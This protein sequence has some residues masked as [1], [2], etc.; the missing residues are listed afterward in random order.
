M[1]NIVLIIMLIFFVGAILSVSL[2]IY[3]SY[4]TDKEKTKLYTYL[5]IFMVYFIYDMIKNK[6]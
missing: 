4:K 3:K 2:N 5:L 1:E 6:I